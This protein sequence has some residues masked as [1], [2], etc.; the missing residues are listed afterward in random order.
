MANSPSARKRIRQTIRRTE[1]NVARRSRARNYVRIFEETLRGTVS[2]K[3]VAKNSMKDSVKGGSGNKIT[4]ASS[5]SVAEHFRVAMSELHRAAQKG[6]LHRKAVSRKISRLARSIVRK[7]SEV[8]ETQEP[9]KARISI[10]ASQ[11]FKRVKV[12]N[13]DKKK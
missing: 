5:G 8:P 4:E 10:K 1:R 7:Q 2:P 12:D 3:T 9:S 13:S 6:A 11:K